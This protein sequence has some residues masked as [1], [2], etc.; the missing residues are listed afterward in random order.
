MRIV[1]ARIDAATAAALARLRR[2][3]GLTDSQLVRKGL[4]LVTQGAAPVKPRRIRGIGRFASGRSDLGSNKAHLSGF[5][6]S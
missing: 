3:T 5:G 2:Q 4:E 6:R 1:Q